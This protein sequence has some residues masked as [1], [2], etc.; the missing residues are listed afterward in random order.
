MWSEC[1]QS[2]ET[3][4]GTVEAELRSESAVVWRG[5]DHDGWDLEVRGGPL[6]S[7]RS[8]ILVEDHGSNKQLVLFR[9]WPR[10]GLPQLLLTVLLSLLA[11]VAAVV[12]AWLASA[13]LGFVAVA[14]ATRMIG[15]CSFAMSSFLSALERPGVAQE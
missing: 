14:L 15:D 4:L 12:Q 2:P 13:I 6:G 7:V 1:W 5:G 3:R 9:M 11:I 8:R 10:V